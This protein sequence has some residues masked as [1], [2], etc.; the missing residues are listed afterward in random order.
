[1]HIRT[2]LRDAVAAAIDICPSLVKVARRRVHNWAVEDLPA[3]NVYYLREAVGRDAV[4]PKQRRD[5]QLLVDLH[6]ASPNDID[7]ELDALCVE[8]EQAMARDRTWS[9]LA[10]DSELLET[11]FGHDGQGEVT[12][13]LARLRYTISYRTS[14]GQI[15]I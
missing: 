7:G 14:P 8:V 6:I 9:K 10:L 12:M 1:M 3:A 5:L 2:R 13:G 11:T 4:A 15:D